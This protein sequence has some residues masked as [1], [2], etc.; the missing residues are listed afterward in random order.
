MLVTRVA[1]KRLKELANSFKAVAVTGPRQSGKTTLCKLVFPD[2]P[3]VTLENPIAYRMATEDPVQF[4]AQYPEG[5][6]LDE[7]QNVPELFSWLQEIL[8]QRPI[9]TGRFILSGSNQFTL[10]EKITQTLAGRLGYVELLPF[11]LDEFNEYESVNYWIMH[12]S[13]PG[14]TVD[15]IPPSDWYMAYL[16]TYI[17]RDVRQ[18]RSIK[19]ISIF[20]RFLRLCAAR[21]GTEL[22]VQN[23][24]I[25]TGV[26]RETVNDWLSILHAS[27]IIYL[28]PPYHENFSKRVVK[29][30]KLYFYDAGLAAYLLELDNPKQLGL[31]SYRGNLF[32]NAVINEFVKFQHHRGLRK[33][34]F[35]FKDNHGREIDLLF[36][37]DNVL[38]AYEIKSAMT[39][40][41]DHTKNLKHFATLSGSQTGKVI[42]AGDQT[43]ENMGGFRWQSWRALTG[44]EKWIGV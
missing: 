18:L 19:D 21:V 28:L 6:I 16:Q 34:L 8:D 31:S 17:E 37:H 23:L 10:V 39:P 4:L 20:N 27:Y 7:V 35:F 44:P 3:Y 26:S 30:P 1:E 38:F 2:K 25:E 33:N 15:K 24:S 13:Y 9:K 29:S 12:G 36:K 42:Y 14:V 40:N 22:N 43:I 41:M 32:E 11:S 5:A